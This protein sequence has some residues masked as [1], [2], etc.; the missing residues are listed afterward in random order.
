MSA[1]PKSLRLFYLSAGDC[2][3]H[4]A[5]YYSCEGTSYLC[6]DCSD[7]WPVTVDQAIVQYTR[8]TRPAKGRLTSALTVQ[9]DGR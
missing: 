3:P 5:T 9:T 1:F 7:R 6:P 2:C 4:G 8:Y